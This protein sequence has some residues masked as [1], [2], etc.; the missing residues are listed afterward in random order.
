[1]HH[2]VPKALFKMIELVGS[3]NPSHKDEMNWFLLMAK[4]PLP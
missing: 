3:Q 4:L 1:M 2:A